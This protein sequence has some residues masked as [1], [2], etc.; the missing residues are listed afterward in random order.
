MGRMG[1][2]IREQPSADLSVLAAL[3]SGLDVTARAVANTA[4]C[5]SISHHPAAPPR[6]LLILRES[7]SFG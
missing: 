7:L 4:P 6:V 1:P 5:C 3:Q 2:V